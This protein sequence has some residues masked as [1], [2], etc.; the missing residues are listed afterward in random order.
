MRPPSPLRRVMAAALL[1]RRT[2]RLRLT[3]LYGTLFLASGTALLA[4]TNIL[5][6]SWPW[7]LY[8][9][10]LP[11]LP[12]PGTGPPAT[13]A[14]AA[15]A[16]A[17]QAQLQ[18]AAH[19][20]A[21]ALN[22]LLAE[23]AIALGIMAVASAALGW[24]IAGQVLRPV[25]QMTAAARAIS[26]DNLDQRLAVPGPGDELKDLGDTI[27]QLLDRIQ[28]AFDAQRQFV[29]NASHELRTP[30]TLAHTLLETAI[31]DPQ[32]T[33]ASHQVTCQR[34]LQATQ[35]QE[36]LIEALLT[37]ARSQR[38]LDHREHLDL[39]A[40]TRQALAAQE[41]GA[42]AHRLAV[43]AS[44]STAPVLA[45][46]RLL[47]R[48]AVNLVANAIQH[49]TPGGRIDIQVTASGGHSR[50]TITNTGPVIP[51]GEVT[52]LLQ[53]SS[54]C[55]P[56]APG[57]RASA[58]DCP[59]SPPSP[60][61]TTPPLLSTPARTGGCASRSASRRPQMQAGLAKRCPR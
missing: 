1:P 21:T 22:H 41:T 61:P 29:A 33:L 36:Q 10:G 37:L 19:L 9:T 25:R 53:P 57:T 11:H 13:I 12:L 2:V 17:R 51:A 14:P 32:P 35:H 26:E 58:W 47:Q 20:R 18:E 49:N 30:L 40:I 6:R 56:P 52:R 39:A 54:G 59:S 31:T 43:K 3:A 45:D 8:E 42:T 27:D 48:L 46:E 34:V 16:A 55:P 60:K 44:I 4:I 50:L 7:P 38:G 24:L 23:S 28:D 15:F 5:A